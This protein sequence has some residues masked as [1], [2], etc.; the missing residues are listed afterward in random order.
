MEP[1]RQAGAPLALLLLSAA[2]ACCGARRH[3]LG[4]PATVAGSDLQEP[5]QQ[6]IAKEERT[7][8]K[9]EAERD[10]AVS[11]LYAA[12]SAAGSGEQQELTEARQQVADLRKQLARRDELLRWAAAELRRRHGG[13]AKAGAKDAAPAK[14]HHTENASSTF[15][16]EVARLRAELREQGERLSKAQKELERVRH[17]KEAPRNHSLSPGSLGKRLVV[18]LE[19]TE[20]KLHERDA[21]LQGARSQAEREEHELKA[22]RAQLEKQGQE[23]ASARAEAEQERQG[24]RTKAGQEER[25]LRAARA[26]LARQAQELAG[27]HAEAQKEVERAKRAE[28]ELASARAEAEQE[29][30]SARAKAGQEE[31]EL[32]AA[33]AKLARQGQEL[34]EAQKEVERAEKE[35][36]SARVEA[37]EELRG[38]RAKTG[39]EERDLM[40]AARPQLAKQERELTSARAEV[41][42]EVERATRAEKDSPV[43]WSTPAEEAVEQKELEEFPEDAVAALPVEMVS[44]A[45]DDLEPL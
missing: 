23:L 35:L 2:A 33:R 15:S 7:R 13:K 8:A 12:S 4:G 31:R 41:R 40:R 34:A 6:L 25:E 3:G 39:Q 44:G 1:R 43:P 45:V 28:K 19:K 9:L 37:E 17:Q 22:L 26:Q 38:A 18:A 20:A 30:R 14:L 24:A 21:E 10:Q 11:A 16:A 32:R 36:A 5:V 29:L 42:K 27:A